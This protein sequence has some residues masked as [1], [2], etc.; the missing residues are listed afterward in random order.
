MSHRSQCRQENVAV[1][2][3]VCGSDLTCVRT[4]ENNCVCVCVHS[5]S[6][7]RVSPGTVSSEGAAGDSE[8]RPGA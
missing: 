1:I 8:Y 5:K 6:P 3:I 7:P 2:V 4:L